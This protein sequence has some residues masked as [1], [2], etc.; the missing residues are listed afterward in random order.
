MR[1]LAKQTVRHL[2]M[3]G[4]VL[5]ILNLPSCNK[6]GPTGAGQ[7][8]S[9]SRLDELLAPIALYPDPLLMQIL[10]ASTNPQ[11]VLDAGNWLLQN[12][13]LQGEQLEEAATGVGFGP[14]VQALVHFPTVVDM[15][16]IEMDWTKQLGQAFTSDQKG[17]LDSVQ[18]LRTQAVNAGSLQTTPQQTVEK[19]QDSGKEVVVIQPANPQVIYVPQYNPQQVYT[20]P[21]A[22]PPVQTQTQTQSSG[23][24]AGTAVAASL[25]TFGIGMAVG[26]ALNHNHYYPPAWGAGAVHYPVYVYRPPYGTPPV[27]H[28]SRPANYPYAYN[29]NNI[30]VQNNN[31]FNRFENNGNLNTPSAPT[32]TPYSGTRVQTRNQNLAGANTN[33]ANS[34]KGQSTY[35]GTNGRSTRATSNTQAYSKNNFSGATPRATVQPGSAGQP[36]TTNAQPRGSPPPSTT[37]ARTASP[38]VRAT[39]DRG[40]SGGTSQAAA[41][42]LSVGSDAFGGAGNG[43]VER[44]ASA[45]GRSSLGGGRFGGLRR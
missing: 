6:S 12:N 35:A 13:R 11:E 31:Y 42:S 44:A 3:F 9:T 18:R 2:L 17:V 41:S 29:Q 33:A 45:R 22:P 10:V 25:L 34:W 23:V 24:S 14:S 28:Y 37:P 36:R 5:S 4:L 27:S 30:Y 20:P 15:M 43:R 7:S 21:P 1:S 32:P 26:S 39:G 8:F 38:N 40:Y 19:K 16:C